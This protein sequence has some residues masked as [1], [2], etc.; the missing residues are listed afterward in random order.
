MVICSHL[1]SLRSACCYRLAIP[2]IWKAKQGDKIQG[3]L[4]QQSKFRAKPRP[5]VALVLKEKTIKRGLWLVLRRTFV[6]C[7]PRNCQ[8][9]QETP[10]KE[11][12]ALKS[13]VGENKVA[14]SLAALATCG[15]GILTLVSP[16]PCVFMVFWNNHVPGA[17]D[18]LLRDHLP[19]E[20]QAGRGVQGTFILELDSQE[21]EPWASGSTS[22]PF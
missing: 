12:S 17:H 7:V 5:R 1:V 22:Q 4:W 10:E 15:H 21:L 3:L 11:D 9:I 20:E 8:V 19:E 2:G 16:G 13:N 14:Q 6:C 18:P